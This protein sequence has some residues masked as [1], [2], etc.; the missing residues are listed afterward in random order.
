MYQHVFTK[1]SN[2][3][4]SGIVFEFSVY[5]FTNLVQKYSFAPKRICLYMKYDVFFIH[6]CVKDISLKE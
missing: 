6:F 5:F 1:E 2:G 3:K 4:Y